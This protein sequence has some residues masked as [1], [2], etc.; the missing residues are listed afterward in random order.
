MRSI[1]PSLFIAASIFIFTYN[2]S[3]AEDVSVDVLSG[4]VKTV[5][6]Q[7]NISI[8]LLDDDGSI[9]DIASLD[10]KGNFQ[11]D[12]TVMDDP[13]YQKLAKLKIRFRDRKG[14]QK[15]ILISENIENFVDNKL[16]LSAQ[17]FP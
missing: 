5:L 7:K 2:Q 14:R 4:K 1:F 10:G 3:S 17:I 8:F 9:L 12:P 6:E 13:V 16:K 11:L 15:E